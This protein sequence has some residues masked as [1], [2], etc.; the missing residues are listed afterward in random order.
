MVKQ[1]WLVTD[2][3]KDLYQSKCLITSKDFQDFAVNH[4]NF[5]AEI[6]EVWE[7]PEKKEPLTK[8]ERDEQPKEPIPLSRFGY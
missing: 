6:V 1:F 4:T 2:L 5:E 7:P 8:K 3:S